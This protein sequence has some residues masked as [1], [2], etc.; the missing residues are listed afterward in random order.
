VDTPKN[1]THQLKGASTL[2][3]QIEGDGSAA[4]MLA[5]VPG[6]G[7]VREADRHERFVGYE[8]E[9]THD[10]RRDVARAIVNKGWGLLELRP[11]RLGLEEV[12]LQL[13]EEAARE[14]SAVESSA[15]P[16]DAPASDSTEGQPHV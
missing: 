7:Q 12:F 10:V 8:I 13:T 3:V 6:V 14:Q 9:S 5:T 4:D 15:P 2:Y 1:L 16:P 11:K